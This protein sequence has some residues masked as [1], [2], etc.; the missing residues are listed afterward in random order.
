MTHLAQASNSAAEVFI[1]SFVL[2][3]IIVV[4]I[5]IIKRTRASLIG[6]DHDDARADDFS[7]HA[8]RS[9]RE[10][11]QI[12]EEEFE[13]ARDVLT[14]HVAP[15]SNPIR[16]AVEQRAREQGDRADETG[17]NDARDRPT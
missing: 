1:L 13:R 8:L 12:T 5:L 2:V 3:A 15:G 9:L 4:A 14:R 6:G 11:G 16:D 10:R 17:D 7:L